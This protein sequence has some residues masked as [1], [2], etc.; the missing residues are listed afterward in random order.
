MTTSKTAPRVDPD[1]RKYLADAYRQAA[2]DLL[3]AARRLQDIT[4]KIRTTKVKVAP[5]CIVDVADAMAIMYELPSVPATTAKDK[6]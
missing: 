2:F 3:H 1:E 4:A 6:T 5:P